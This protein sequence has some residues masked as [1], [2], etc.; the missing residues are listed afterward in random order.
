MKIIHCDGCF[1]PFEESLIWWSGH[2]WYCRSCVEYIEEELAQEEE[3][4]C[5][6]RDGEIDIICRECF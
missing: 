5:S 6:C 3:D 1:K 2:F 4:L